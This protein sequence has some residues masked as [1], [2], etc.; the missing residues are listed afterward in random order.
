MLSYNKNISLSRKRILGF[1][2]LYCQMLMCVLIFF[3]CPTTA[4]SEGDFFI[5]DVAKV[6]SGNRVVLRGGTVVEYAG[7]DVLSLEEQ[8]PELRQ[9]AKDAL[10]FNRT[11]IGAN[12]LRFEFLDTEVDAIPS[13]RQA[14]VYVGGTLINGRLLQAGLAVLRD[15]FSEEEKFF[16]YFAGLQKEAMARRIGI[17]K[18]LSR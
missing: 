5:G 4:F 11:L 8:N 13:V 16:D 12:K 10:I 18:I 15:G 3:I 2:G 9:L 17:W 14:Y 7:I 1:F 6:L